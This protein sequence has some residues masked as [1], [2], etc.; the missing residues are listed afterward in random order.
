MTAQAREGSRRQVPALTLAVAGRPASDTT[1]AVVTNVY[2]VPHD[3]SRPAHAEVVK[4][5]KCQ[6]DGIAVDVSANALGGVCTLGLLEKVDTMV[7][8]NHLFKRAMVLVKAWC[9]FESHILSSQNGLLATYALETL[10][11]CIINLFHLELH[12]P[13]AVLVR[14]LE[15]FANFDW[16]EDCLTIRGPVHK[17]ELVETQSLAVPDRASEDHFLLNDRALATDADLL[18]LFCGL[19]DESSGFVVK[20][21]NI[22]DPLDHSNNLGRSVSRAN[23][24]RISRAFKRGW[25]DVTKPPTYRLGAHPRAEGGPGHAPARGDAEQQEE[26]ELVRGGGEWRRRGVG[27][28]GRCRSRR[29]RF[30]R[31]APATASGASSSTRRGCSRGTARTWAT[32][33]SRRSSTARGRARSPPARRTS[34]A[35][36]TARRSR[37][38]RR[39]SAPSALKAPTSTT[40]RRTAPREATGPA[41]TRGSTPR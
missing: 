28:R 7:G 13:L 38:P 10:V 41:A 9:Y 34:T 2:S 4:V 39:R 11:L 26:S 27:A 37:R 8:E 24:Y 29:G 22:C 1:P 32:C 25:R 6:V 33:A 19:K 21:L 18:D 35:A 17:S 36:A 30:G 20:H 5:V 3:L 14:F 15:Y 16:A 40:T 12:T 23:S 31:R